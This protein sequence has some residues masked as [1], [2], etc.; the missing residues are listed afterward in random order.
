M[1]GEVVEDSPESCH[2]ELLAQFGEVG[3]VAGASVRRDLAVVY[4]RDRCREEMK[5]PVS[6][7][8]PAE[9]CA[10]L[11]IT[12]AA[13]RVAQLP[14]LHVEADQS[15]HVLADHGEVGVDGHLYQLEVVM[16]EEA[17]GEDLGSGLR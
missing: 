9:P 5:T 13:A 6:S 17:V 16:Y 7:E 15:A 1:V 10:I 11:F 4:D 8:S 12:A 2:R 3:I 14:T